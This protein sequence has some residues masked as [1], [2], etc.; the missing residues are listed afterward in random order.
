MYTENE[1]KRLFSMYGVISMNLGMCK[2]MSF[3]HPEETPPDISTRIE[4][5]ERQ[6]MILDSLFAVTTK[7]EAFVIRLHLLDGLG[8]P[9][10]VKK[11]VAEWEPEEERSIRTFQIYQSTALKKIAKV[12]N[13]RIDFSWD[14]FR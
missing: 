8:W 2:A 4:K 1:V 6:L 10:I 14:D 11:Y 5:L 3:H 7:N 13:E 12:L 9:Q